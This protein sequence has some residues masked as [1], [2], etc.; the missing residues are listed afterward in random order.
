[1]SSERGRDPDMV[2]P[3]VKDQMDERTLEGR[4]MDHLWTCRLRSLPALKGHTDTES[5]R[6]ESIKE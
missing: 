6:C 2:S 5:S 3:F 4:L 1:M